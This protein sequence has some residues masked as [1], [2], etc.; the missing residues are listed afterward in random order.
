MDEAQ[1]VFSKA[2]LLT[3]I[4]QGQTE[5]DLTAP[6]PTIRYEHQG[7]IEFRRLSRA[8]GDR[9]FDELDRGLP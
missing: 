6:A 9:I 7:N 2:K 1:R 8:H 4:C 5:M 3:V